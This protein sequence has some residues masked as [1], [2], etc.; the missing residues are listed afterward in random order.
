MK[1]KVLILVFFIGF[2]NNVL[3]KSDTI[4]QINRNALFIAPLNFLDVINPSFQIGYE[5]KIS[6]NVSAQIEAG[7]I[8]R[9]SVTGFVFEALNRGAYW[10]T[11]SGHKIR[12][13]TKYS[14]GNKIQS[15]ENPY[16][17]CE[18]F[19]TKNKSYVNDLFTI[20]DTTFI[21]PGE[22]PPGYH[23]YE[24][25]FTLDKQRFGINFKIGTKIFILENIF[26]EPHIG[27]GI[28]Y[29][30]SAHYGRINMHDDFYD[31]ISSFH[32]EKGNM[33]IPNFPLNV[34]IGYKF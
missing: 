29:R 15:F 30:R 21:Y 7:V 3:G 6:E 14:I 17:S 13:E 16:I 18:L 12:F 8:L 34:K 27:L 11:N 22:R 32:N 10:Y 2:T 26:F 1:K 28:V 20:K 9:H 5:R 23:Q 24:D 19:Y 31:K 4:Q 33:I 25:F